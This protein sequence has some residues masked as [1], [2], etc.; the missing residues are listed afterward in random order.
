MIILTPG[1][2]GGKWNS[3]TVMTSNVVSYLVDG[4]IHRAAGRQLLEECKAS[5]ISDARFF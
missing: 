5:C 4:A 2:G 3:T 1:G